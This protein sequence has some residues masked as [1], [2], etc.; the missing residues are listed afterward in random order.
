MNL[1]NLLILISFLSE[2]IAVENNGSG[3]LKSNHTNL[4]N[5]ASSQ[6]SVKLESLTYTYL[7]KYKLYI[8]TGNIYFNSV[9]DCAA[10]AGSNLLCSFS[11]EPM[12][13]D[14]FNIYT[15]HQFTISCPS[16]PVHIISESNDVK[17]IN[18]LTDVIS[19]IDISKK[20]DKYDCNSEFNA[21]SIVG[22]IFGCST[23][24]VVV[25]S[26]C[27]CFMVKKQTHPIVCNCQPP[28]PDAKY[29]NNYSTN[30]TCCCKPPPPPSQPLVESTNMKE[31]ILNSTMQSISTTATIPPNNNN[32]TLNTATQPQCKAFLVAQ[33][34]PDGTI[35]YY[36]NQPAGPNQSVLFANSQTNVDA[37][38][39]STYHPQ[40]MFTPGGK[41]GI[42][43]GTVN[44]STMNSTVNENDDFY[45]DSK[46]ILPT[47]TL[48]R[49]PV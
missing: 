20:Y 48:S 14:M 25:L 16:T 12:T 7:A 18:C 10:F 5:V 23:I 27:C 15:I 44:N 36:S 1:I 2:I 32:A 37:T 38:L 33:Q 47:S 17:Y 34:L 46:I 45:P 39:E 42:L 3:L 31:P 41:V 35:Q 21:S 22:I 13:A 26:I 40:S 24:I 6:G 29:P 9:L 49:H 19:A 8:A 11:S 28:P 4:R 43:P 30:D